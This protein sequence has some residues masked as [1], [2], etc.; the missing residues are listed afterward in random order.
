MR[1]HHQA[2]TGAIAITGPKLAKQT[3]ESHIP[4]RVKSDFSI[5]RPQRTFA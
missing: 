3:L 4:I 1:R 5:W 2:T